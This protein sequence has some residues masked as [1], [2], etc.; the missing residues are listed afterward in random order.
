MRAKERCLFQG[1]IRFMYSNCSDVDLTSF[2]QKILQTANRTKS[3]KHNGMQNKSSKRQFKVISNDGSV[4]LMDRPQ[5][6]HDGASPLEILPDLFRIFLSLHV[7]QRNY[8]TKPKNK[9][10]N[11]V[12]QLNQ[13][14]LTLDLIDCMANLTSVGRQN[15]A[16]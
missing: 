11:M 6:S 10:K 12:N 4:T 2:A 3:L 14:A 9:T 8:I 13:T 1:N 5:G 7:D 16:N 15:L